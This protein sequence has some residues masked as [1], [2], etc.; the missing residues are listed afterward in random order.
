MIRMIPLIA[1]ISRS[2]VTVMVLMGTLNTAPRQAH[3]IVRFAS[4]L[5]NTPTRL[6][7]IT[8]KVKP[9]V[10]SGRKP[11]RNAIPRNNSINAYT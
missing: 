4:T 8:A 6:T 9:F 2:S 3:R 5:C 11:V 10:S 7:L 1:I